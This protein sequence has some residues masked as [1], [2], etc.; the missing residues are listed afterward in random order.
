MFPRRTISVNTFA[1]TADERR[2][3][4]NALVHP[5]KEERNF[6]I[7]HGSDDY[8]CDSGGPPCRLLRTSLLV[9]SDVS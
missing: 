9:D 1:S 4:R 3:A 7:F 8:P 2:R 6:A 5:W